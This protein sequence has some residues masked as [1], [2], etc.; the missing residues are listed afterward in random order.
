MSKVLDSRGEIMNDDYLW[1]KTGEP[2]AEVQELEEVLGT[3][4]YRPRPLEFPVEVHTAS[5]RRSFL[6]LAV[7]VTIALMV[8]VAGIWLRLQHQRSVPRHDSLANKDKTTPVTPS[9]VPGP[10]DES[11]PGSQ[12]T[13]SAEVVAKRNPMPQRNRLARYSNRNN[14]VTVRDEMTAAKREEVEA[15]KDQ[16]M[17][18]LRVVSAKLNLAQ[19]KTQGLPAT[20]NIRYQHKVG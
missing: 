19:R 12:R 2:D 16:L 14:R 13:E 8:L 10:H 1:D 15:A 7:A 11:S 4:R 18:A 3:L 9:P 20:N 6:S 17:L 5:R